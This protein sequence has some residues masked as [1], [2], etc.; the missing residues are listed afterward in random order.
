M[1]NIV[2]KVNTFG[3]SESS[4]NRSVS[5]KQSGMTQLVTFILSPNFWDSLLSMFKSPDSFMSSIF[6]Y[7]FNTHGNNDVGKLNIMEYDSNVSAYDTYSLA[8]FFNMGKFKVPLSRLNYWSYNGFSQMQAYLPFCG[9]VDIPLNDVLSVASSDYEQDI[10]LYFRL[11]VDYKSGQGCYYVFAS[12]DDIES[13]IPMYSGTEVLLPKSDDKDFTFYLTS[14]TGFGRGSLR[15]RTIE[16]DYYNYDDEYTQTFTLT[17]IGANDQWENGT[18]HSTIPLNKYLYLQAYGNPASSRYYATI[19]NGEYSD[20]YL[21]LYY[22][23]IKTL[24][25]IG[26]AG[27]DI[28]SVTVN[29]TYAPIQSQDIILGYGNSLYAD[30]DYL[31]DSLVLVGVYQC[32]V[33]YPI[34]IPTS[35]TTDLYRNL[36]MGA[37][38]TTVGAIGSLSAV[39]TPASSFGNTTT[40]T[41]TSTKTG[42]ST[43]K[44]SRLKT[45]EEITSTKTR[46]E[47]GAGVKD[48][49]VKSKTLSTIDSATTTLSSLYSSGNIER[50][51]NSA[52]FG[53]TSDNIIIY[54][55][56]PIFNDQTFNN[57]TDSAKQNAKIF[58][59]PYGKT[60]P[61]I[62]VHG[63]TTV[64]EVHLDDTPAGITSDERELID[65]LLG[66]GVFLP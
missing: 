3:V 39:A 33:G 28:K 60:V 26:S 64:S 51:S 62:E 22:P 31:Y 46:T 48:R 9:L 15:I 27:V 40:T 57:P 61:L 38:K 19:E 50:I 56:T 37:V 18:S 35:N 66:A 2:K 41:F 44:G 52:M 53:Y 25:I 63:Y 34:P 47:S 5:L 10:Y 30:K 55:R 4:T 13:Y 17:E 54:V 23:E 24:K 12:T 58:G 14:R 29:Y 20:G 16:I 59:L 42:R 32:Q 36:L 1:A 49:V 7:P 11:A 45:L 8:P 21:E 65:N 6:W 43:R